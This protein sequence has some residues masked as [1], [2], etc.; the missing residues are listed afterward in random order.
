[1]M[2]LK[3]F[4]DFVGSDVVEKV[5]ARLAQKNG[6]LDSNGRLM[7]SFGFPELRSMQD[8]ID[9]NDLYKGTDKLPLEKD[10]HVT[11]ANGLN[12]CLVEDDQIMNVLNRKLIRTM[13]LQDIECFENDKFDTLQFN[14]TGDGLNE[15][16]GILKKFLGARTFTCPLHSIVARL[17]PGKG[18]K[19]VEM[20]KRNEYE[21]YPRY[22]VY[23]KSDKE[24]IK[25]KF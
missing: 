15:N 24:E 21:V 5:R 1:M 13:K 3:R 16:V 14:V 18:K 11:L 22:I 7:I 4:E 2:M 6:K 17:E 19:Y 23:S 12:S 8:E 9:K 10:P 25:K 20:F